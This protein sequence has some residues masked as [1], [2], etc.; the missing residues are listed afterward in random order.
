MT[1]ERAQ[2]EAESSYE[3]AQQHSFLLKVVVAL[4][5]WGGDTRESALGVIHSLAAGSR[6]AEPHTAHGKRM[7]GTSV[8]AL[9][10]IKNGRYLPLISQ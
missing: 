3:P 2:E 5:W 9:K 6:E 7:D 8:K 4:G 10:I 1:L